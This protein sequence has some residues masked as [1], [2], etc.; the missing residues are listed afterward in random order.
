MNKAV[1]VDGI[2]VGTTIVEVL[3]VAGAS[4]VLNTVGRKAFGSSV[5]TVSISGVELVDNIG[6]RA[7]GV[8]VFMTGLC[9]VHSEEGVFLPPPT[10]VAHD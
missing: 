10:S 6:V 5:D 8:S 3:G 9:D 7:V 2:G 1:G 4:V